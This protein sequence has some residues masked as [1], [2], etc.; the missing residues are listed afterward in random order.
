MEIRTT[1][2]EI[3][4]RRICAVVFAAAVGFIS[5]QVGRYTMKRDI[6]LKEKYEKKD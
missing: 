1:I 3:I 5:Y 2:H 4:A 6:R